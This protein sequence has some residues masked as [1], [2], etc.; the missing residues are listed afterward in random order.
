[1]Y[2]QTRQTA[3]RHTD[4]SLPKYPETQTS[5]SQRNF[6]ELA[7]SANLPIFQS[8]W[9]L[10]IHIYI[11]IQIVI[12]LMCVGLKWPSL[13]DSLGGGQAGPGSTMARHVKFSILIVIR[14][15][16]LFSKV[17]WNV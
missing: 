11:Y 9:Y 4:I 6:S 1:M 17:Y 16:R 7:F 5:S 13:W 3:D 15:K 2:R 8:F 10:P 14:N 12:H